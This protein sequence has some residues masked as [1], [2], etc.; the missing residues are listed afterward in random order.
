[1][2]LK[3]KKIL[4]LGD[5]ITEGHGTSCEAARF[6]NIIAENEGA[7]CYNYGIGGTRLAYQTKPSENPRWD[8]C[9]LDRVDE[10]ED[11]ADIVVVFGGTNDYGHGDAAIGCFEDRDPYTFYGAVHTLVTKLI[12]KYP[13]AKLVFITQLHRFEEEHC[14]VK[15]GVAVCNTLKE[16]VEILREVLEYYSV[17]TLDL[18]RYGRM[19]PKVP[20][21]MEKYMPDGLHPN[22]AGHIML[23]ESITAYLKQL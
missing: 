15:G 20:V 8:L 19:Q 7:E 2:E 1:M 22:D 6:T 10:M 4:F 16:Y 17:P 9:F 12:N 14:T 5:S 13:E 11:T 23:A 18:Y 3:G 21:I